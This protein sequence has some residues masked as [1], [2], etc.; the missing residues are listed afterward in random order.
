[1]WTGDIDPGLR[2]LDLAIELRPDHVFALLRRGMTLGRL[3]R[4]PEAV[5]SLKRAAAAAP[6]LAS[7]RHTLGEV[8]RDSGDFEGARKEYAAA[9]RLDPHSVVSQY[10]LSAM[11]HESPDAPP[12]DYVT[13]LFNG[14]AETFERHLVDV[15]QYRA[16]EQVCAAVLDLAGDR[17]REWQ[18]IDLGCGTGLCGPLIR[19]AARH[20]TG[21]DLSAG[22]LDKARQKSIYDELVLGDV[23][24]VLGSYADA[25]D[26][27]LCTDVMI[28]LGNLT[29]IFAAAA[30]ALKPG[31]LFGFT[32]E[33]HSG[34][35]FVVDTSGR[36]LHSRRYVEAEAATHGFAVA[37]FE[38]FVARYQS[39][40][41]DV[42][43]LYVVR[44][45]GTA[46]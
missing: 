27:A 42:H 44:R 23:A 7:L 9:V 36:Y 14:Y 35:G 13:G 18:V 3:R 20:L 1:M 28:Y 19:H 21:V 32:T 43:H 30:R 34:D 31:A 38:P 15:L 5:A 37:H 46:L 4:I 24:Q 26:L 16:P 45:D 10:F 39:H 25:F 6:N 2:S 41:P 22:M 8:L 40:A 17:A 33:V 11:K 12:P 29:P